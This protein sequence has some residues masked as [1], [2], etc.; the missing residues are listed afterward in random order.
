MLCLQFYCIAKLFLAFR[1][2]FRDSKGP[3]YHIVAGPTYTV[4]LPANCDLGSDNSVEVH[5]SGQTEKVSF[6]E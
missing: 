6:S 2:E 5:I 3:S 1:R 4:P